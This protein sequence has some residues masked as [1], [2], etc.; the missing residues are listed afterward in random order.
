MGFKLAMPQFATATS[1]PSALAKTHARLKAW[2][3]G[4]E[5]P[6]LS[7]VEPA[8]IVAGAAAVTAPVNWDEV[9]ARASAALW[10]DG[11]TYP[12][13]P[14]LET[15][16]I[17]DAGGAKASRI[18]LFGGGVG[19]MARVMGEKTTA[20]IENYEDDAF[21]RSLA[22]ENL[23]ASKQ[24]KRFG[25]HSFDWRPSSLPKNKVDAAVMMFKG[26]QEGRI[27]A[28]AFCVERILRPGAHA[29]WFDFFARRD[30]ETL[31][32]CRGHESRTFGT[33]DEAIITFSAAGLSVVSDQDM[34]GEYLDCFE[35]GWRDLSKNLSLRQAA[36]IK[37]GGHHAG[38]S[39]LQNL[40]CWKARIEAVRSG[41]LVV[42]SYLLKA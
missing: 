38:T 19:G 41:K 6:K 7:V 29:V 5:A 24:A 10:A 25:F 14:A 3:N 33:E 1:E 13:T 37:Q 16:I 9:H 23:K 28:A 42:R 8:P 31:D 4:E 20:K 15:R 17:L 39:A 40:V 22:E 11:R 35:I 26:G 34:S 30:D 32:A 18:A 27:E 21:V 12:C 36:L 2:W